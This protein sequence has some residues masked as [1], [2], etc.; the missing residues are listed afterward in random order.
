V[1]HGKL[2]FFAAFFFKAEH[3]PFPGTIVVFDLEV[4]DGANPGERVGK[5]PKQSAIAEAGVRGCLDHAQKRLNFTFDK[6]RGFAFGPRKSLGL[7][8]PG[9]IH[10]QDSFF[11]Q[12]GKHHPD[13]RHVLFDRGRVRQ[14][15]ASCSVNLRPNPSLISRQ[16]SIIA[17][18]YTYEFICEMW[19]KEPHRI[20]A[21][22]LHQMPGLNI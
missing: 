21:D 8:F 14:T 16:P 20:I 2:F 9:R 6:R 12:P 13:R 5:D 7:Y 22:P 15:A 4:H 18:R 19:A 3:K 10:G 17:R 1:V 11:R